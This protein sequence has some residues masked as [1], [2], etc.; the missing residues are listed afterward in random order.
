MTFLESAWVKKLKDLGLEDSIALYPEKSDVDEDLVCATEREI[1]TQFNVTPPEQT[2]AAPIEEEDD[3][4]LA[5]NM[6]R[7][8]EENWDVKPSSMKAK[9][10]KRTDL[11]DKF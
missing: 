2:K 4:D 11:D 3:D 5:G 7:R 8:S 9:K 10:R 1:G 6:T